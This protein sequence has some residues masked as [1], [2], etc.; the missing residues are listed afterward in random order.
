[1]IALFDA[2]VFHVRLRPAKN[3]FRY[4]ATYLVFPLSEFITRRRGLLSINGRNLF[5]VRTSDYGDGKCPRAWIENVLGAWGITEADG[6][7]SLVTMPR[8]FG[9]AFNPVNFWLCRDRSG[10]LR[11]VLAE[12][13]NTF[14]ERHYYLCFHKDKTAIA[15]QDTLTA[16][17]VFHVSPFMET[18]GQ[19]AF[20][21]SLSEDRAAILIDLSD[22]QGPLL[23]TSLTGS[24]APATSWRLLRALLANPL[25][26]FK[27]I[28]LIHYQAVKLFLKRVR[29]VRKPAPPANAISGS[30]EL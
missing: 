2:Q 22:A 29:H 9:Y 15:P 7:I 17:K 26:P 1:M 16:R 13:N 12:V 28:T 21:F 14:G 23:R 3:S 18:S 10:A 20:R 27:A 25:L 19:Y 5:S 24:L 11:A 30:H 4:G 6:E 8:I